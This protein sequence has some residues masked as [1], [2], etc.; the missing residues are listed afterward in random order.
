M[1][2]IF[3][4]GCHLFS[5]LVAELQGKPRRAESMDPAGKSGAGLFAPPVVFCRIARMAERVRILNI[6]P[7]SGHA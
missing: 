3:F 7:V 1:D 5:S 6:F 4:E 2:I